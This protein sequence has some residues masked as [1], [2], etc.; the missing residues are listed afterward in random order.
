MPGASVSISPR[1]KY[2]TVVRVERSD[3]VNVE[4]VKEGLSATSLMHTLEHQIIFAVQNMATAETE[5][6]LDN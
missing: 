6:D 5:A 2:R 3:G 4:I 1:L